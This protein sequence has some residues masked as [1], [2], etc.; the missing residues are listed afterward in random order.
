MKVIQNGSVIDQSES[1]CDEKGWMAGNGIFETIKTVNNQPW[2]LSRHMRR[3]VSSSLRESITMPSQEDVLRALDDLFLHQSFE[4]GLLRL[5]F[6][7]DGNW[8]AA[9]LQYQPLNFAA[10]ILSY[11]QEI[12]IQGVPIKSFPY[13]HRLKILEEVNSLGFDEA[14]VFNTDRQICEGAVTNLIFLIDGLWVTPP[15]SDGALPG[16]MRALAIEYCGVQVRSISE[17]DLPRVESGYLLSSLRIAQ[18]I[19][20]IDGRDLLQTPEF[21][22]EIEAMALKTSVG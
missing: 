22:A 12:D 20:S 10:K 21:C 13:S 15:I 18:P 19:A 16:V 2:A 7:V 1:I 8:S 4:N 17:S 5:S 11:S 3:A 6:G 9:H 14:I